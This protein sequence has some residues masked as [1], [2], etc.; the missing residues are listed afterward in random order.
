MKTTLLTLATTITLAA[1][2]HFAS[3]AQGNTSPYS[4]ATGDIDPGI[5]TG[6]GTLDIVG[7]EVSNTETDVM[8]KLTVNGN[9][10]TI[11]WGQFMI[12]ISTANQGNGGTTTGNGWNRPINLSYLGTHGM[13]YWIG[14]WVTGGGGSQLWS[15]Q[16]SSWSGPSALAGYSFTPGSTSEIT[17]TAS[18][19]SLGLS[20]G[21]GFVFDAYT[22]GGGP[23]DG[24]VDSLANPNVSITSWSQTYTS[25]LTQTGGPGL[26]FYQIVPEPSTWALVGL[27]AVATLYFARRRKA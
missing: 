11:D 25:S 9:V 18:L 7:M 1:S 26:N 12:G 10:S 6:G 8:F 20:V 27:G 19:A 2:A 17:Y 3:A 22:S 16:G 13:D 15:W 5:S 23:S 24:A 21:G 4:D 14:S